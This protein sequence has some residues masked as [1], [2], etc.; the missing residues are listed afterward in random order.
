M[1]GVLKAIRQP[2]FLNDAIKLFLEGK[3]PSAE[4]IGDYFRPT[5]SEK[6]NEKA[7]EEIIVYN[8][9]KFFKNIERKYNQ[10]LFCLKPLTIL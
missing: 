5:F 1:H 9:K 8:L 3:F 4:K 2:A 6:E 7:L 10:V